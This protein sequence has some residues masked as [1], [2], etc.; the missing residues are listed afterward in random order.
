MRCWRPEQKRMPV[1]ARRCSRMGWLNYGEGV[2]VAPRLSGLRGQ[3]GSL[4]VVDLGPSELRALRR[5]IAELFGIRD[6]AAANGDWWEI[7][8][9]LVILLGT[10][11]TGIIALLSG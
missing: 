11:A 4:D 7:D 8:F 9:I 5:W 3:P 10:A 2:S 1:L 6:E